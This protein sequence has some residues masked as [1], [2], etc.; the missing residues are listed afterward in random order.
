MLEALKQEVL[1]ANL[2]LVEYQLVVLT[3]GNVSAISADRKYV[4]IKPSGVD[5]AAMT[6][7]QM[8][9]T[10]LDGHVIEGELRPSS[11]LPTHLEIYK[12]F[13]GVG[14]VVHT[15]SRY[16]TALAQGEQDLP[17]Y[18]T[19]HADHFY[20]TV[21][22]TRHLTQ[23][24]ITS[25]YERNTGKVIVET[26]QQRHIDPLAVPAVLVCKHGPFAWGSSTKKAVENALVLDET[27]HMALL[28]RIGNPSLQTAPQYLQDKHYF[29]KHGA[30]AYYGQK[31]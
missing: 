29:R 22:C 13:E 20:G 14:S 7:N 16:A 25:A 27:S 31:I 19:T 6:A 21:P 28:S 9:V 1:E 17:C 12:N 5:Y 26:F 15:H 23:E 10:D 4:V 11:D 8:V 18:G 3:W 2:K 24:E 30:N